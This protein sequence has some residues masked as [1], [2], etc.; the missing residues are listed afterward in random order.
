VYEVVELGLTKRVAGLPLVLCTNPSDQVK[1][2]GAVPVNAA[3]SIAE[4][5]PLQSVA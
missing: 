5:V 4:S 3:W 2:Q 1:A